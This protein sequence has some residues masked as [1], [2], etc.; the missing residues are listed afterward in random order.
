M[1]VVVIGSGSWGTALAIKSALAGNT[2]TIY[3]RRPEF[4]KQ[5][6]I[7]HENKEYLPGVILPDSLQFSS[8]LEACIRNAQIVLMVTPSVHVRTSLEAIQP[9][10]HKEQ[11]YVLCSKGVERTTGKLLTTV[12]SEILGSVGCNLAVLTGPNHAEEVARNLPAAAVLSTENL[13][14]AIKLQNALHSQNFRIYSST[15]LIGVELAGATKNII[16]LA[17]GIVDGLALGDNCKAMLLTRGLHE[18]TRFG[19][20]LGAKKETYAGLAGMGDLIATCMSGHSRN[21]SAGQQLADGRTMDDIMQ[22][23]NMVVEGFFA[24]DII[25]KMAEEHD[26]EMPITA[27]L[28]DV[29]HQKITPAAALEE[30][31]GRNS[32]IEVS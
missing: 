24:T 9:Y 22:H 30:L 26:I 29:L 16:A 23:T 11:S 19:V 10:A 12:M 3:C 18:M 1:N 15:D 4:G 8:D 14:V 21:R 20:A 7:D 13:D 6:A 31:M 25:H 17:A 2:T 32:K 27:A 28:H 5:L